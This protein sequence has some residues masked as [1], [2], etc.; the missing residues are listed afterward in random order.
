MIAEAIQKIRELAESATRPTTQ[1]LAERSFL[2]QPKSQAFEEVT[3]RMP[4]PRSTRL[5]TVAALA[6]WLQ[7]YGGPADSF[8]IVS[9]S[10]GI[11]ARLDVHVLD[12][13]TEEV[14]VPFFADDLPEVGFM[15]YEDVLLY[16][17][18]HTGQVEQEEI[19]RAA[20]KT[21][22]GWKSSG[23]T[24]TDK[25]ASI[26]IDAQA[27][28]GV[29][30]DVNLPKFITMNLRVLTREYVEKH[31]FRLE[32]AL[33]GSSG[34]TPMFK[35]HPMDREES[36]VRAVQRALADLRAGLGENWLIVEGA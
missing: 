6:D 4:K 32:I 9:P 1:D 11:S 12:Y 21:V 26:E 13:Q 5:G 19:L 33:G 27:S 35:F 23:L 28:G 14:S 3:P 36:V 22:R 15:N 17:D 30:V 2:F 31:R 7:R 34:V 10:N 25:G 18:T 24:L 8:V 29:H 16:L 20:L